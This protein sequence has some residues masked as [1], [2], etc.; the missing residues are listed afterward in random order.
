MS[1]AQT[2]N[3]PTFESVWAAL[4]E[5]DRILKESAI[6]QEKKNDEFYE[7]LGHL[8]NL[9]G[10]VTEAMIAPKICEKF[11]E[12][13][14]NFP[15]ANP[16]VR[17]NDRVNK[18]SFEIDIMLENGD[19]A[20]LVEVKTKLTTERV[21]KNIEKLEKMRKYANL[22]GDK[23]TFLGAVACIVVTDEVRDYALSQGFYFIEYAGENFYIT[24]PIGKPKEW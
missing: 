18:I 16:N 24:S 23:R 11:E 3:P 7:K 2:A 13:G 5:T 14:L 10:D 1:A 15:R 19:K 22:H 6:R 9:F 20:M 12:F 4:Q 17:V 21:N 8:T